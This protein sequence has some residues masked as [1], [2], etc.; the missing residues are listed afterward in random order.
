MAAPLVI[1]LPR[2]DLAS[3]PAAPMPSG[4][5]AFRDALQAV[6]AP[7]PSR[8][9]PIAVARA[10]PQPALASLASRP[11]QAVTT[12][13][14]SPPIVLAGKSDAAKHAA[15]SAAATP[16][17]TTQALPGAQTAQTATVAPAVPVPS[18]PVTLKASEP[19]LA[20]QAPVTAA[21]RS[22]P[23]PVS[24]DTGQASAAV[25]S[26]AAPAPGPARA[27]A[28]ADADWAGLPDR[29]APVRAAVSD[30]R[31]S[32]AAADE[33]P[34][35][36]P[37]PVPAA[38]VVAAPAPPD[39]LDRGEQ[40]DATATPQPPARGV[41]TAPG[42]TRIGTAPG[43]AGIGT[44]SGTTG[45]GT[46]PGSL[47]AGT[48]D[49]AAAPKPVTAPAPRMDGAEAAPSAA[50][51]PSMSSAPTLLTGL[52]LASVAAPDAAAP[53]RAFTGGASN[54]LAAAALSPTA[55]APAVAA[56]PDS[57]ST[58]L[59]AAAPI[60]AAAV[61]PAASPLPPAPRP[62]PP[63]AAVA[64]AEPAQV[65]RTAYASGT[66]VADPGGDT[67]GSIGQ[68]AAPPQRTAAISAQTEPQTRD[69][70]PDQTQE[71]GPAAPIAEARPQAGPARPSPGTRPDAMVSVADDAASADAPA[72]A[73]VAPPDQTQAAA[74][75][76]PAAAPAAS[77]PQTAAPSPATAQITPVLAALHVPQGNAR[78]ITIQLQP[79]ELGGVQVRI[80]HGLD[81]TA[82]VTLQAERPDTLHALQLDASHLHQALDRAGLPSE[83]RSVNFQ[84]G[85]AAE[86]GG[87]AGGSG[88]GPGPDGSAGGGANRQAGQQQHA[89]AAAAVAQAQPIPAAEAA[90][91]ALRTDSLNITA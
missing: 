77:P 34:A 36:P 27:A 22:R 35:V 40:A 78:D 2:A 59:Q 55:P 15:P 64:A 52:K 9:A 32:A 19:R 91:S 49:E 1:R 69:Q 7:G 86:S 67:L 76:A 88:F 90:P 30:G 21:K 18:V 54:P 45:T 63:R 73:G 56:A 72:P 68:P 50:P 20:A 3:S 47:D 61:P 71:A 44:A 80:A 79:S 5:Q 46:P 53:A 25:A 60:Q 33:A 37:R 4:G 48:A 28:P 75:A 6:Q 89:R 83:G 38:D 41:G 14:V 43:A 66:S 84:L 62:V 12:A 42:A 39:S 26:A 65:T 16:P 85:H 57:A 58:P 87:A 24:G 8:S 23:E 51:G 11:V 13:A 10:Q 74:P 17:A 81:G 70:T 31:Q 29:A 82:T